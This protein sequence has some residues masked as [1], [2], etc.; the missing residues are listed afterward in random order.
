MRVGG[1]LSEV[2][3]FLA[4]VRTNRD[5]ARKEA[6][7]QAHRHLLRADR[8]GVK[9]DLRFERLNYLFYDPRNFEISK[10]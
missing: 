10:K 7:G 1:D 5:I 6:G 4:T 8:F 9:F 3:A 2:D